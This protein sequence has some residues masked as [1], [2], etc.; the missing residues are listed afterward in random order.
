MFI[1]KKKKTDK[2]IPNTNP[3]KNN[4]V[5]FIVKYIVVPDLAAE[6]QK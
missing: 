5:I 1:K 3:Q 6:W 2:K 4:S